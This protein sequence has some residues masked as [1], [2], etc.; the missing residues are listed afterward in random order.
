MDTNSVKISV[1]RTNSTLIFWHLRETR[2][3]HEMRSLRFAARLSGVCLDVAIP[4]T[5]S[6]KHV[7]SLVK[8]ASDLDAV[9]A[10]LEKSL[11]KLGDDRWELCQEVNGGLIF[12]REK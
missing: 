2:G 11:N 3:S 10:E 5:S 8:D 7:K 6:A 4:H 12:K 9:I 1:V